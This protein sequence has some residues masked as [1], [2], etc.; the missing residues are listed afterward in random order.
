MKL[1]YQ[2]LCYL[3]NMEPELYENKETMLK[4]WKFG[5]WYKAKQLKK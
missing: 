1:S 5:L 4:W 3:C 2:Q